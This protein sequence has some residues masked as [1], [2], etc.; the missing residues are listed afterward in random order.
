MVTRATA[1]AETAGLAPPPGPGWPAHFAAEPG[2]VLEE[3]LRPLG[4]GQTLTFIDPDG[5]RESVSYDAFARRLGGAALQLQAQGVRP[6]SLVATVISTSLPSV[7]RA[8]AVW[9]AGAT[10]VSL[11]PP[12]RRALRDQHLA[13]LGE[14]LAAM[15]CEFLIT[16]KESQGIAGI[17]AIPAA[18]LDALDAAPPDAAVPDVAL[19]QFTSGSLGSPKGVAIGS[20]TLAGHLNMISRCMGCEPAGDAMATWLPFYHDFGLICFFLTGVCAR[21]RQVHMHPRAFAADPSSWLRLLSAE[22]ATITGAP[23]FGFRLASRVPY[24]GDLDL[25]RVRVA[26]N[27]GER[28]HWDDLADFQRAAGPAGFPWTAQ[29]PVYGMAENTVGATCTM[30]QRSGPARG[31]GGL[32]SA[33]PNLPGTELACAGRPGSP[34]E[35]RVTGRWLYDGYYTAAGFAPRAGAD[36]ATGDIG[37]IADGQAFVLG[38][39]SEVIS[40]GGRNLFAEDV[41]V[42]ASQAA[43]Q[44]VRGCAAFKPDAASQRFGMWVEA[45]VRDAPEG[46]ALAR[47]IR[48][49]VSAELG[50]RVEPLLVVVPGTIPRTSSGKVQRGRCRAALAA[51]ELP[52]RKV[53]AEIS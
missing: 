4:V 51:G 44:Q 26:L 43:K 30:R 48:S 20:A 28:I 6:G 52:G 27:G 25:S 35:L 19:I 33:G 18:S 40:A 22:R 13:R 12:P 37:F 29:L 7:I 3:I 31:P 34:A 39:D 10:L 38:R 49:A 47:A 17:R 14:V 46:A 1:T 2:L 21:I 42:T 16:E 11:P 32:V 9:V 8:L 23:H 36:L 24:P 50:T 53:I 15:P 45:S 5:G 41:E